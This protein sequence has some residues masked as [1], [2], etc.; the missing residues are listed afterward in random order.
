MEFRSRYRELVLVG[1][2]LAAADLALVTRGHVELVDGL[3]YDIAVA[4]RSHSASPAAPRVAVIAIDYGSESSKLLEST[5]RVFYNPFY[6]D[7]L[8]GLFQAGA[9]AVGFDV[10]FY[11]ASRFPAIEP[12]YDDSLL[13]A[14][15]KYRERT[16]LARTEKTTVAEPFVAAVFDPER[17]Q[18]REEPSAI[19]Y[20]ELLP[21]E[22]GVQRWVY[23]EYPSDGT[24]LKTLAGRLAEIA[25]GPTHAEEF[26]LAPV[27]P[28]ES[29]PTYAFA[30]VLTCIKTSP[31]TVRAA[32]ADRVVLIG[33]NLAE[34]DRKRASDRFIRWPTRPAALGD[35]PDHAPCQLTVLGPSAPDSDSVPGV[36]IHAAAIDS[37]LGGTGVRLVPTAVAVVAAAAAGVICASLGLFL[38]PGVAVAAFVAFLVALFAASVVTVAAGHWLPIA[39]PATASLGGLLGGQLARFFAEDRRRR[40]LEKAFGC[41]LAPAIVTQLADAESEVQLGGEEREVTVMFADLTNFTAI[42]DTMAPAELM[43]LTNFYFKVIVDVID[44]MGGYVDKFIGDS[45]MALWG[46]PAKVSDAPGLALESALKIQQR[47]Q[48]L[49]SNPVGRGIAMFDAKVG[50]STGSAIVGNVGTPKRLSYTALGATINLAAR[51]EKVC[52]TF[53]CPIV[54]D[55]ATMGALGNRYL[56]CELDAVTLKGKRLPVAVYEAIARSEDATAEQR[57]YVLRY[58]AALQSYRAGELARAATLWTELDA[59]SLRAGISAARVMA[60]RARAGEP[61]PIAAPG[62]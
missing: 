10:I 1:A 34:E 60:Q 39:V 55:S 14:L 21:D 30:D 18:G 54:V 33:G 50:M 38:S 40:R 15:H 32:F 62:P 25:G 57:Q 31:Q 5:P 44:E 46:A 27:A 29:L 3:F 43:G 56:F 28:L 35:H 37:L 19:A 52:S 41:Y 49:K 13:A 11:A 36:H 45:V 2:L 17:D 12:S 22:D 6:A 16:V 61:I 48:Q 9:K 42:S 51:L 20:S 8:D 24:Q 7:L 47:V 26:L 4:L 59:L 58:Q 23:S 53:G